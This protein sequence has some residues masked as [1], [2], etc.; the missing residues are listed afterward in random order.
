M[1][2]KKIDYAERAKQLR[3]HILNYNDFPV[4]EVEVPEWGL[5]F[6]IYI[7]TMSAKE[8]DDFETEQY[9]LDEEGK[10]TLS[11]RNLRAA[12]L[13]RVL[14]ADP[15]GKFPIFTEINDVL[16]LGD[17][18]AAAADRCLAVAYKLN[19]STKEDEDRMVKNSKEAEEGSG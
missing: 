1:E 12:M 18:S 7:R 14:C 16:D 3:K 8:K 5:P 15:E 9:I 19:G 6:P 11:Y 17:K 4:E 2:E 10:R 13:A